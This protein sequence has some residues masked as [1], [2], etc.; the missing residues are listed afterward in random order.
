MEKSVEKVLIDLLKTFAVQVINTLLTHL[1]T[2]LANPN[3]VEGKDS[4]KL[5]TD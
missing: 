3:P 4:D 1:L 5:P 2:C